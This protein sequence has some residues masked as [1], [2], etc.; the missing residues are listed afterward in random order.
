MGEDVSS[1]PEVQSMLCC[2]AVAPVPCLL[3]AQYNAKIQP[4]IHSWLGFINCRQEVQTN[5][6]H[7]ST[8]VPNAASSGG[9]IECAPLPH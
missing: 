7:L 2:Y 3:S 5:L 8:N 4:A 9:H 1:L 6:P